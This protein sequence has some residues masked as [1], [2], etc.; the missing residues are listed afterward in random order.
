MH[1]ADWLPIGGAEVFAQWMGEGPS[2]LLVHTAGQNGVQYR[3]VMRE[4]ADR[5]YRAVVLDLPGHGRSTPWPAGPVTDLHDYAEVCWQALRMLGAERPWIAGCSIGGK[6]ALDLAVN[7]GQD[8]SGVVAMEADAFNAG[9]LS[10]SGLRHGLDDSNS[11]S[12]GTRTYYGT[13]ASVGRLCDASRREV[14]ALMHRRED[15]VI[16]GSDLLGWATHDLRDGLEGVPCPVLVV[17]GEDDFWL[18]PAASE[19]TARQLP[20]GRF[21]SL[22]GVGH[23]P[24]EE[25]EDFTD[26]LVEWLDELAAWGEPNDQKGEWNG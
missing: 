24:M 12:A 1:S 14:I 3:D 11:P 19:W 20:R 17:A 2:V 7:H 13:H 21:L 15:H 16:S 25:M 8:L 22:E 6:I 26:R 18:D 10:V 5:G 4:L 9:R 23:Y